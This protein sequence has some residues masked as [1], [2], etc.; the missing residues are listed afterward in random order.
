[1]DA[2]W[3]VGLLALAVLLGCSF[4]GY[5]A[6]SHI[7][8][9]SREPTLPRS[10]RHAHPAGDSAPIA[11]AVILGGVLLARSRTLSRW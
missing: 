3:I 4:T 11:L 7:V 2:R 5:R 9:R 10:L 6:Q 8:V 1:M